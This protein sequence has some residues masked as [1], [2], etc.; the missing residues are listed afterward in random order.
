MKTIINNPMEKFKKI[1]LFY[2]LGTVLAFWVLAIIHLNY[3]L[4]KEIFWR[5]SWRYVCKNTILSGAPIGVAFWI[6]LTYKFPSSS[7]D[8]KFVINFLKPFLHNYLIGVLLA[9]GI[10]EG[11]ELYIYLFSTDYYSFTYYSI[12]GTSVLLGVPVAIV[13]H[14]IKSLKE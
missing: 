8:F 4:L 9:F 11:V 3:S 13:F 14:T 2:I 7:L 5:S 12:F 1:L 10:I 6:F